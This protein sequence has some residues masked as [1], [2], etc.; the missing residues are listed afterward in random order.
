MVFWQFEYHLLP[1]HIINLVCKWIYFTELT[2][3]FSLKRFLGES[4]LTYAISTLQCHLAATS[5][6]CEE[7]LERKMEQMI[8]ESAKRRVS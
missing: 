7:E 1:G 8:V 2:R 3:I 4:V 6:P 5:G